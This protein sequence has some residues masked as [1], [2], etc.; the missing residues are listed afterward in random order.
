MS[1]LDAG[2]LANTTRECLLSRIGNSHELSAPERGVVAKV[3]ACRRW[4][5]I[6]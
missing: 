6:L 4:H 3:A 2:E 5:G 1:I